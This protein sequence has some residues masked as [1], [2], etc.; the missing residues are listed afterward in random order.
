METSGDT[1]CTAD[2]FGDPNPGV[3]K[4]CA[5]LDDGGVIAKGE[6]TMDSGQT[7]NPPTPYNIAVNQS[8][9]QV[10]TSG[11]V[12]NA[13]FEGASSRAVDGNT[14]GNYGAGSCTHTFAV[15]RPWWRVEFAKPSVVY[16]VKIYGRTDTAKNCNQDL[17]DAGTGCSLTDVNV[18]VGSAP[19]AYDNPKCNANPINI[20]LNGD[21]TTVPC[22]KKQG[23]YVYV[24]KGGTESLSLCEVEVFGM[25]VGESGFAL[26]LPPEPASS[27]SIYQVKVAGGW[28]AISTQQPYAHVQQVCDECSENLC[29]LNGMIVNNTGFEDMT[30]IGT[31]PQMCIPAKKHK[32][33]LANANTGTAEITVHE[34]GTLTAS[35]VINKIESE[36]PAISLHG[37]YYFTK[38]QDSGANYGVAAQDGDKEKGD[39]SATPLEGFDPMR[40]Y[41][42]GDICIVWGR[43]GGKA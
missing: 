35:K 13:A 36:K 6:N 25:T 42:M 3:Q 17:L 24:E 38:M 39:S 2:E 33:V 18:Y 31:V 28:Q 10:S 5:I 23:N 12:G 22:N 26:S 8:T 37:I 19:Y 15:S 30:K 43:V 32:F 27:S 16:T 4:E 14:N 20:A 9:S 11:F 1:P 41:R 40:H 34:S 29:I 7:F 21:A